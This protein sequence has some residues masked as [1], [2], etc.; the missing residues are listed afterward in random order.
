MGTK[1]GKAGPLKE[2][3][4]FTASASEVEYPKKKKHR[5]KTV[6]ATGRVGRE[7]LKKFPSV[8]NY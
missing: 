8:D 4:A 7:T 6:R 5:R 2:P 3:L 1:Q